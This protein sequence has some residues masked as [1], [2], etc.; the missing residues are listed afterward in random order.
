M[1][2]MDFD[3][4]DA[5]VDALRP[6]NFEAVQLDRG[7]FWGRLIQAQSPTTLVTAVTFGRKLHQTGEPPRGLRTVGILARPKQQFVW[8]G[9]LVSGDQI[10]FFPRGC[11]LDAVSSPGFEIFSVSFSEDRISDLACALSGLDY[12]ELLAGRE[13]VDCSPSRIRRL[14]RA[15]AM[16]VQPY[17]E[18][19]A[20][21][22]LAG[23]AEHDIGLDLMEALIE[24]L[25]PH[26]PSD[27]TPSHRVRDLAV[28]R[29]LDWIDQHDCESPSVTDLCRAARVSRRTLEYAFQDRFGISPKA[30]MIVRRLNGVRGEIKRGAGDQSITRS[31]NRWGFHHMS[32][33]AA[34]YKRQFGELPSQTMRPGIPSR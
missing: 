11:E 2:P 21:P 24:A 29:T 32:Q 4:F 7:S 3:D 30:Y 13:I 12:E 10:V 25:T 17:V 6:W 27:P 33:F 23:S 1:G 20:A 28:R 8:R 19:E 22:L 9:N 34:L 5:C 26:E 14:R 31:A 18:L 15:A 16:V